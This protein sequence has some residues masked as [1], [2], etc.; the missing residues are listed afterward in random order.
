[1]ARGR[2]EPPGSAVGQRARHV[3]LETIEVFARSLTIEVRAYAGSLD[4]EQVVARALSRL[5]ERG[6]DLVENNCEHFAVWCKTGH[7]HSPP[8]LD[9][10]PQ[11]TAAVAA[12]IGMS[13]A[14]RIAMRDLSRGAMPWLLAAEG[15]QLA[16][17]LAAAKVNP[18]APE[19]AEKL[20]RRIGFATAIGVGALSGTL[21]GPVGQARSDG[22]SRNLGRGRPSRTARRRV[23]QEPVAA[24]SQGVERNSFRSGR[25][26]HDGVG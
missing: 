18:H 20:G 12:R 2:R 22:R 11:R 17:E 5:G 8:G 26:E 13:R 16:T 21:G 15:V 25:V 10:S 6:Y 4:S 3:R 9:R 14:T 23:G 24:W 1:M 7:H 19:E